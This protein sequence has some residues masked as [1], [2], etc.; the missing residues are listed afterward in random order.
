MKTQLNEIKRMQQLAGILVE[1]E[2]VNEPIVWNWDKAR[3]TSEDD[4]GVVYK[5]WG[6]GELYN[7][8]GKFE[9]F[10]DD[11]GDYRDIEDENDRNIMM[12]TKIT[13]L[14]IAILKMIKKIKFY[15][16]WKIFKKNF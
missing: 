1:N 12:K 10:N 8:Y 3:S 6:Q 11:N 5:V 7:Y 4:E 15:N 16:Q 13:Y 9:L 14:M 2:E